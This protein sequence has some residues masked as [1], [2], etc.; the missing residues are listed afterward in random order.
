ME[1]FLFTPFLVRITNVQ[2]DARAKNR[3]DVKL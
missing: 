1:T 2:I 3:Y